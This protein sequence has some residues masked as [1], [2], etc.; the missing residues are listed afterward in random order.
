MRAEN[1]STVAIKK[2]YPNPIT[3]PINM[4]VYDS[5][6]PEQELSFRLNPKL[7]PKFETQQ[8]GPHL[9][10]CL[11]RVLVTIIYVHLL[12]VV[13]KLSTQTFWN[14][15][16]NLEQRTPQEFFYLPLRRAILVVV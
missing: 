1:L 9:R 5:G 2:S 16:Q 7:D 4:A 15:S 6:I 13:D 12:Y 14:I 10:R 8:R 11:V 3:E